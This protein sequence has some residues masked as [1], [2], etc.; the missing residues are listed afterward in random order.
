VLHWADERQAL[1][2]PLQGEGHDVAIMGQK[3]GDA[4]SFA[5]SGGR[6][7]AMRRHRPAMAIVLLGG[8][9]D[10]RASGLRAGADDCL[11]RDFDP[12][13]LAAS[14]DALARRTMAA[15]AGGHEPVTLRADDIEMDLLRR[16]VTRAGRAIALMP[17]EFRILE[18][19]L[20][21][22]DRVV[23]KAMLLSAIERGGSGAHASLIETQISRLR[24]KLNR[25]T[26]KDA[27]ET[28]RGAGY[29]IRIQA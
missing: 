27:I 8:G 13:E 29:R 2:M 3:E 20:R 24:T 28:V 19:L 14:I 25:E 11:P 18:H 22:R 21:H 17:Q 12:A 1:D 4:A 6:I 5:R 26:G 23:S 9:S 7:A 16:E 15:E 10:C